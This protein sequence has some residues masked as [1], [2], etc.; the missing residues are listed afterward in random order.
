M[1]AIFNIIFLV[2]SLLNILAICYLKISTCTKPINC[3]NNIETGEQVL[4]WA[5]LI[6]GC[7]SP[8]N[9]HKLSWLSYL[10]KNVAINW[11]MIAFSLVD[12]CFLIGQLR[13]QCSPLSWL[14]NILWRM[15][16]TPIPPNK[17]AVFIWFL[18]V[19]AGMKMN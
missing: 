10:V 7:P 9:Y 5:R 4:I 3:D 13:S 19:G 11:K 18:V 15:K 1:I 12:L 6:H 14:S 16:N 2:L 17:K 8:E